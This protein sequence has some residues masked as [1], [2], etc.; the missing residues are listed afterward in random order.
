MDAIPHT[1][2][3]NS[4]RILIAD[5]QADILSALNLLL[6][7]Q[8]YEITTATSPAGVI[9]L[10]ETQHFDVLLVDLNYARDTTSG[11]EGLDLMSQ[12]QTH[13]PTLP[14]IAMTAWGSVEVAVEAMKGELRD[15]V[16]KPWDNDRLLDTIRAQVERG[17]GVRQALNR[18]EQEQDEARKIQ[19]G[20][21][22]K[23]IPHIPGYDIAHAW[24]PALHVSGDYF[25]LIP[26]TEHQLGFCIADVTGKGM[27]AALLMSNIQ[28]MVHA[29]A[30]EDTSPD[31][32]CEKVNRGLAPNL[33]SDKFVTFFYGMLDTESHCFVFANAGHNP[34]ILVRKDGRVIRL[35]EGGL[36]LGVFADGSYDQG[37]V[38]IEPGDRLVLFTDGVTEALNGDEE[39][40]GDDR[41]IALTDAHR[42]EDVSIIQQQILDGVTRFCAGVYHDDITVIVAGRQ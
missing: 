30:S 7:R 19:R 10:L 23:S 18:T 28:A 25:D 20:L 40:F 36:V 34:P 22:P 35:E 29:Y 4:P 33:P 16:Q 39:E 37:R 41:L 21:M 38:Y 27:P 1:P 31:R 14:V 24:Q 32:L 26:F 13:D 11:R 6:K 42:H 17:R 15:F 5:D 9:D 8:G 3:E 12:I 2:A